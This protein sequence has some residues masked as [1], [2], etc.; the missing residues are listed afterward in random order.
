M[1]PH[2]Q[3]V[4]FHQYVDWVQTSGIEWTG[5]PVDLVWIQ[6]KLKR[7]DLYA[8]FGE[9]PG[10]IIRKLKSPSIANKEVKAYILAYES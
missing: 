10:I 1:T 9:T 6:G 7:E 4:A 3:I 5:I 2:A 8:E